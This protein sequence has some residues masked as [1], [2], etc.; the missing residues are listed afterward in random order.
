[1]K[2]RN[3]P[4]VSK[5]AEGLLSHQ[6]AHCALLYAGLSL[7]LFSLSCGNGS[8]VIHTAPPSGNFTNASLS[9]QYAYSLSGSA[10]ISGTATFVPYSEAGVFTADGAGHITNGTDDFAQSGRF[11]SNPFTGTYSLNKDGT[12]TMTFVFPNGTGSIQLGVTLLNSS[13]FYLI[14]TDG[15]AT[16]GGSA[17]KQD[18]S[19]FLT[20]PS[21]TFAFRI[22]VTS[23]TVNVGAMTVTGGTITGSEDVLPLGGSSSSPTLSGTVNA[24]GTN[25]RGSLTLTNS[26]GTTANFAYYVVNANI[27]R[28][29]QTD[30]GVL[31]LGR[32][33]KQTSTN[34]SAASLT[35]SFAFGSGG[36]TLNTVPGSVQSAGV[37]SSDGNGNVSGGTYDL[38]RDG[39]QA[40]NVG[41]TGSY[42]ISVAGRAAVTLNL[43]N[44]ITIQDVFWMVSPSRGF[45]LVNDSTKLEDGTLDQQQSSSFSASSLNGQF[46]FVMDGFDA[47]LV[48]RVGTLQ[49]DG[50]GNLSLNELLNR[51]GAIS[52]PGLL[53]GTY[54]VSRNG[55][56]VGSVSNLSNNL[57]FYMISGNSGYVLQND[58]GAEIAGT[59]GHQ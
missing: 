44:G 58:A 16:G 27:L 39:N 15:F 13:Q 19:A 57:V 14:E 47:Q 20:T 30:T 8:T 24:P 56:A 59:V 50:K 38:V 9:G 31:A 48:D 28:L 34:F 12:G 40:T 54:T 33:E 23:S 21:G 35:G 11:G 5:L 42:T 55:R 17:E 41:L 22:H 43:Q 53:P 25:G 49:T 18:T 46:A 52:A 36:D 7:V 29:L 2:Q 3:L 51:E 32:A 4:S 37:F 45:F 1:M 10:I 26:N 6:T